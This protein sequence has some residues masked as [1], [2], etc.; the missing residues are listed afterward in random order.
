MPM[1][2]EAAGSP[3]SDQWDGVALALFVSTSAM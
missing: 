1:G 3:D 2:A